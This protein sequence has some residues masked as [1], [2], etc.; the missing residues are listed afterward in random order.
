MGGD[1]LVSKAAGTNKSF[2]IEQYADS[3]HGMS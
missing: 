2:D 3:A 1:K